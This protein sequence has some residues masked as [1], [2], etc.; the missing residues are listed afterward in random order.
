MS[1]KWWVTF[2]MIY[3]AWRIPKLPRMLAA[4]YDYIPKDT[5]YVMRRLGIRDPRGIQVAMRRYNVTS[6]KDLVALLEYQKPKRNIRRRIWLA[7]ARIIGETDHPTYFREIRQKQ[8]SGAKLTVEACIRER[9]KK[10][11]EFLK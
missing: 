8:P 9:L 7:F 10:A 2:A 5:V 6:I 1:N 3:N 4:K 11:K